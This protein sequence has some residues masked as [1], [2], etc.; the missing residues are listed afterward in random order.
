VCAGCDTARYCSKDCQAAA[1]AGHRE[2]CEA[3]Q[4]S[5]QALGASEQGV[6]R[7]KKAARAAAVAR[8]R[9]GS[10]AAAAALP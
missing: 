9:G 4:L 2:I 5:R 7:A 10:D 3:V 6:R 8:L 1:W